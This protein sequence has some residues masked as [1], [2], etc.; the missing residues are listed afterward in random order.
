MGKL[1]YLAVRVTIQLRLGH[2]RET[3]FQGVAIAS[4][5]AQGC[6]VLLGPEATRQNHG[7]EAVERGFCLTQQHGKLV[8]REQAPGGTAYGS[9][10]L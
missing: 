9:K 5:G 1:A 7:Q 6:G 8:V 3:Q 10:E 2:G 4:W